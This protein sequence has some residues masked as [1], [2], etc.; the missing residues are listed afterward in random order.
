MGWT[1]QKNYDYRLFGRR[2]P[3]DDMYRM[4]TI[5]RNFPLPS[6]ACYDV[7]ARLVCYEST[8]GR[9]LVFGRPQSD[10]LGLIQRSWLL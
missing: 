7:V 5:V 6:C 2:V 4:Y 9:N 8:A 10:R 1:S 3:D